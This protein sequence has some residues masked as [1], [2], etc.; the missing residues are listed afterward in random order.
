MDRLKSNSDPTAP[1]LLRTTEAARYLGLGSKAIRH[2]IVSRQLP[3]VQMKPGN[4][5][6]LLDRR[7]LDKFIEMHKTPAALDYLA[8]KVRSSS[9]RGES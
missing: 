9:A 8:A 5:P 1:R 3:F 7:D 6:F 4:S 2:L